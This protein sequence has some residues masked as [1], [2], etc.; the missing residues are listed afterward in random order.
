MNLVVVLRYAS[1]RQGYIY[2]LCTVKL[3]DEF[4]EDRQ[5]DRRKD[6]CIYSTDMLQI[7]IFT[8]PGKHNGK[9]TPTKT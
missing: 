7:A 5:T 3:L 6:R 9:E 4:C 8:K 2:S 1:P